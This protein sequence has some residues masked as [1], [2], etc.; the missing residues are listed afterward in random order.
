M[1]LFEITDNFWFLNDYF[2]YAN[3][4]S[5]KSEYHTNTQN[6]QNVS[7]AIPANN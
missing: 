4:K 6:H 2:W 5:I 3:I 1:R 7:G